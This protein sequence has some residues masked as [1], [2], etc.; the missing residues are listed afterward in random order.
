[1][2][3]WFVGDVHH[4]IVNKCLHD[5]MLRSFYLMKINKQIGK[6]ILLSLVM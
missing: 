6:N 1:M 2:S 3:F 4:D 5:A